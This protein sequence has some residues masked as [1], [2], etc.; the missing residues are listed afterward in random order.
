[1]IYLLTLYPLLAILAN[2]CYYAY[3]PL[4]VLHFA[5]KGYTRFYHITRNHHNQVRGSALT[6]S[7]GMFT[8]HI[9]CSVHS[10]SPVSRS[11]SS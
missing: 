7:S 8:H 10:L 11:L 2:V 1:M 4:A 6:P 5:I 3:T 9:I